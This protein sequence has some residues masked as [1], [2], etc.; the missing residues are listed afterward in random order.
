MASNTYQEKCNSSKFKR[1]NYF[2]GMLLT[3]QDFQDEQLYYREKLKLHNRLH[4]TGVVWGL[5]LKKVVTSGDITKIYISAGLAV[6]C[7]GDEIIVCQDYLVP[8]KDKIK[9]LERHGLVNNASNCGVGED[10]NPKLY[11]GLKYCECQSD[12]AEQ[13]TIECR[14]DNPAPQYSRTREGFS[15]QILTLDEYT[16][17]KL[18]GQNQPIETCPTCPGLKPCSEQEQLIVLGSVEDYAT[19]G[20]VLDHKD[21]TITHANWTYKGWDK[22]KYAM[23]LTVFKENEDVVDVSCLLGERADEDYIRPRLTDLGLTLVNTITPAQITDPGTF[24]ERAQGT[25]PWFVNGSS[26]DVVTDAE[27]KCVLFIVKST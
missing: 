22:Q 10:Q 16:G 23:L 27:K 7:A 4:G 12:P 18:E 1:L 25:S 2:H 11:I 3:E 15:V 5:S 21:A 20:D 6:D 24:I 8:L 13:Y 19:T 17:C 14:G 9:E 26:V